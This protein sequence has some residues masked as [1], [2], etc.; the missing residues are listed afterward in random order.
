MSDEKF[1]SLL[2]LVAHQELRGNKIGGIGQLLI[3]GQSGGKIGKKTEAK[4]GYFCNGPCE[5]MHSDQAV[6]Q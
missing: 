5:G 3:N 2:V 1:V 6:R 4:V